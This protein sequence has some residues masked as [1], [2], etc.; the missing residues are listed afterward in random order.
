MYASYTKSHGKK[1][2]HN[3]APLPVDANSIYPHRTLPAT[4]G[5]PTKIAYGKWR[6]K[7]KCT[8]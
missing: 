8:L 7:L 4:G 1:R 5:A 2:A 6:E 3:Q